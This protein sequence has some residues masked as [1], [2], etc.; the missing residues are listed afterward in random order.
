[1][2]LPPL[3]KILGQILQLP[4]KFAERPFFFFFLFCCFSSEF[5]RIL[6]PHSKFRS[7]AYDLG[8]HMICYIHN[9]FKLRSKL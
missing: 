1:M 9:S 4:G 7:A 8:R 2:V 3:S 5:T 6:P